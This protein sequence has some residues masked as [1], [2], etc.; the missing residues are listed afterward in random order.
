M[1]TKLELERQIYYLK[2][3]LKIRKMKKL[4]LLFCIF[5]FIGNDILA[6][7]QVNGQ[8]D[9][10]EFPYI[11]FV[12]QSRN[13]DELGLEDF[14]FFENID[15]DKVEVDS[16]TFDLVEDTVDYSTENKC[17]L[18]LIEALHHKDRY[19]QVN[20]FFQA[21]ENSI[22]EIVNNGDKV[23]VAAFSL[24]DGTTNIL[25]DVTS[26]YTDDVNEII[27]EI[28]AYKINYN[29]FTNKKV[30]DIMGAL[31]EGIESLVK[32]ENSLP[33][34]IL[35][36]SEERKNK[37]ATLTA[38]DITEIARS[39]NIV[40]NTI[41]YNRSYYEQ[42]LEPTLS[43][44]TYGISKVLSTSAGTSRKSNPEKV[45]ESESVI[46][47][48]LENTVQRASGNQYLVGVN[49]LNDTKGG[50]ENTI[51]IKQVDSKY[52]IKL[53]YSAPGNWIMAQFQKNLL[54]AS[55]VS[56]LLL[57]ILVYVVWL[58]IDKK[59]QTKLALEQSKKRQRQIDKEQESEILKQKQEILA[60]QNKES[61]R[62]KSE[63]LLQQNALK[64]SE[65]K[66]LI[67]QMKRLGAFP[68]LKYSDDN[69]S[70][71]Y[72]INTPLT[73]VG[74]DEKT[75]KICIPN[76]NISRNHFSI[77]FSNDKYTV[78]DNNSTNGMIINGYKLKNSELKNGDIIEIAD[79][80]F[81]FYI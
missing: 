3:H 31:E 50:Q 17:V 34:S 49:A 1:V 66:K 40:I 15:G 36:L 58:F 44:E 78:V 7:I 57:L 65:E 67:S 47:D 10:A 8:V 13:P 22:D 81:T 21:V 46:I 52:K 9:N 20:T 24:R 2:L 18:I 4:L 42:Y 28:D 56:F 25:H 62:V 55:G 41:K 71:Q 6:Q 35:L 14:Q 73:T 30:S 51:T 74:R 37:Y 59:K 64:K 27:D 75:N 26:K 33:K 53:T 43:K 5:Q 76:T 72:E 11:E 60:M 80:T 32:E 29:D 79:V 54:L 48:I 19:E 70:A 77:I 61:Q 12:L 68:I 16:I 23:K 63:Q 39:K 69:N 38:N 45:R